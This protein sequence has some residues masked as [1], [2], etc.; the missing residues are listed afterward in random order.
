MKHPITGVI[1][2]GGK[3][4]R[5]PG[6]NKAL[7]KV[8]DESIIY[9][10]YKIYKD[11]FDEIILVTNEPSLFIENGIFTVT[12]IFNVRSSLTGIHSGLFY[13]SN[14]NVF[15]SACDTPFLKK[16]LVETILAQ[17]E[18]KID[19]VIPETSAGREPLCAVYSRSCLKPIEMQ[20]FNNDFKIQNIF[21]NLRIK[22]IKEDEIKKVDPEMLSFFNINS[23]DDLERALKLMAS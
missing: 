6:K 19:V 8:G 7:I 17:I 1:L 11:L 22:K 14:K 3:N 15:F 21:K 9:K 13:S 10:I 18:N 5:L 23:Q 2:A 12:D 20:L 4:T 16:V